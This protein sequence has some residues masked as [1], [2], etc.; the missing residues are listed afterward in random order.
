MV[1]AGLFALG[2][3]N[4]YASFIPLIA[5]VISG[6]AGN[7]GTAIYG[8]KETIAEVQLANGAAWIRRNIPELKDISMRDIM[9][10]SR[11]WSFDKDYFESTIKKSIANS[12]SEKEIE[13]EIVKLFNEGAISIVTR[14]QNGKVIDSTN[15]NPRYNKNK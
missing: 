15:A 1:E 13:Q 3:T 5:G 7:I 12:E 14:D 8:A 10:A 11:N 4:S 9:E 2:A 6:I